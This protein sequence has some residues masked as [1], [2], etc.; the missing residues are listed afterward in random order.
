MAGLTIGGKMIVDN[1][2][3]IAKAWGVSDAIIG[4]TIVAL[5]TSLPELATSVVAAV[6]KNTDLAIGNVIG[7]NIFNIFFILGFSTLIRPI[8]AYKTMLFDASMV[9][10][11]SLLL[12]IFLLDDKN[13]KLS[14]WESASMLVIYA[15]YVALLVIRA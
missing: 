6:K 8:P 4:I 5:G 15:A 3:I 13:H 12:M 1:A 2:T 14:R 10:F 7:S 11:S 9:T